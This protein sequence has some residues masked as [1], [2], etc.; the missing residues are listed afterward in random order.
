MQIYNFSANHPKITPKAP[1]SKK[2]AK[3]VKF[4]AAIIAKG[5]PKPAKTN[6]KSKHK[7]KAK[8][9]KAYTKPRPK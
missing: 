5:N 1:K 7:T 3:G 6:S 8:I 4:V 2:P 9:A